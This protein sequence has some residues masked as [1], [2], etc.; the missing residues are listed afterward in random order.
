M[1]VIQQADRPTLHGFIRR[2]IH[3]DAEAIYTDEHP[4]YLGIGDANAVHERVN[5]SAEEWVRGK[6]H[7]NTAESVW[8]LFDRSVIGAYHHISAK[9]MPRY[10]SEQEW[11]FNNRG[12]GN[13]FRDTMRKLLEPGNLEYKELTS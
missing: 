5:H 8:S 4:A 7:T 12:N 3:P 6:V 11:R 2:H 1:Q 10:L 13:L 9:H